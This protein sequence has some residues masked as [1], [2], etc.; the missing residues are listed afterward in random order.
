MVDKQKFLFCDSEA[1]NL[2]QTRAPIPSSGSLTSV[3]HIIEPS[4]ERASKLTN[5]CTQNI[6]P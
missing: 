4:W 1:Q 6:S 2:R 3:V 5:T